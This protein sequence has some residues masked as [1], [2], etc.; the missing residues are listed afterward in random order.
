MNEISDPIKWAKECLDSLSL[1]LSL[2]LYVYVCVCVCVCVC[3]ED[4]QGNWLQIE[5]KVLTKIPTML[6]P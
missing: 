2:S 6:V 4:I 5:N 3:D 1:S